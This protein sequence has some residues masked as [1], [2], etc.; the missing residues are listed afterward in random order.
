MMNDYDWPTA[1]VGID[2]SRWVSRAGCR[3]VLVVVHSMVS[4]HRLLDVVA[5]VECDPR[6]Q[7]VFTVAPDVFNATAVPYL[8]SLG[9]LILPWRQAIRERFDLAL[10]AASGGLH[11]VHAPLMLMAHGAG[12]GKPGRPREHGGPL[13]PQPTVYG[14]DAPRLTRDGRVLAAALLLAHEY[15]RDILRRQCPEALPVAVVAGDPCFDRLMASVAW[16]DRYRRALGVAPGQQVVVVSSTWGRNGLFGHAPD[17]L[18]R[19]MNQLPADRYRVMAALHPA[20][21]TAHGYRQVRA[22]TQDCRDA[23]LLLLEPADDWRA[24]VVAA[25]VV[26]GDHGSVTAYGAALGRP[27]LQLGPGGPAPVPD[28]AQ[29]LV[30]AAAAR[31]D[32]DR[33]IPA[34]LLAAGRADDRRVAAALSS[35][36]G[37]AAAIIRRRMY[38]LLRLPEPG[39]HRTPD[40]V[41][42]PVLSG[43]DR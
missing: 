39:R 12:R 21:W 17:L 42:V 41:P 24:P 37:Q 40:P 8:R 27:V 30:S 11:D 14:L 23:G 16:R 38:E 2:A 43:S 19:L 7:A 10:A 20:V 36:P 1:P 29:H 32:P 4:C 31:L 9:A 35:R 28:S 25:D 5:Y 3:T 13:L 15:E 33:P 18:P 26:I 22:W 34:Q 6:I